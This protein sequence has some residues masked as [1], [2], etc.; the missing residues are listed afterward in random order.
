MSINTNRQ[1]HNRWLLAA[2]FIVAFVIAALLIVQPVLAENAT[3]PAAAAEDSPAINT[4]DA[5][6]NEDCMTCHRIYGLRMTLP[7]GEEANLTVNIA[8]LSNSVHGEAELLCVECHTMITDFPHPARTTQTIRENSIQMAKACENCHT[9]ATEHYYG[10]RHAELLLRGDENSAVCT[11]CH[12]HH[13]LE[14]FS[15]SSSKIAKTCQKCHSE[16]YDYYESSVHG[17][18]LL[19]DG[20]QDVPTCESCHDNHANTGPS[21]PGYHLFSPE[22]CAECHTNTE[23][24]EGYGVNTN[25]MES[26]VADFHGTT[27]TIFEQ[28]SPDQETNKPVCIDCHGVHN[29]LA[30]DDEG[31]AVIKANITQTCERCHE[32]ASPDFS[33]AWLSHYQPSLEHNPLVY[34]IDLFYKLLIPGVLGG[35]GLFIAIDIYRNGLF[36]SH[37][38]DEEGK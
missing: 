18:A 17:D 20:N 15:G 14:D 38:H 26:Y 1:Q 9:D 6:S 11:D 5:L 25:V 37:K 12:G 4:V 33:D 8:H 7:S 31:S 13:K 22:I 28:I 23:M 36:K 19:N 21:D 29:I 27:I 30:A 35:M 24:M 34:I 32:G 2:A 10:G 3:A 16:V